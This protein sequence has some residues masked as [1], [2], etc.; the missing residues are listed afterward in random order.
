M[1]AKQTMPAASMAEEDVYVFEFTPAQ[2]PVGLPIVGNVYTTT[3]M[4]PGC[5]ATME[6][7]G[8]GYPIMKCN[9]CNIVLEAVA[10]SF[11]NYLEPDDDR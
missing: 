3:L 7:R 4:C 1:C 5:G 9:D 8:I 11:D 6:A 10:R 2:Y